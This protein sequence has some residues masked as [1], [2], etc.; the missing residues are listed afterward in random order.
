MRKMYEIDKHDL[1]VDFLYKND[2]FERNLKC[3]FWNVTEFFYNMELS[4]ACSLFILKCINNR[5]S[6]HDKNGSIT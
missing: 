2:V 5:K 4:E 3:C 6:E 1:F